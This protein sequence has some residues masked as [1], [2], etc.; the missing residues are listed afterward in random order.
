MYNTQKNFHLKPFDLALTAL[1][2]SLNFVISILLAPALKAII[3]Q[4]FLGA[5]L[6][7]PLDIFLAYIVWAVTR[8][9][10]FTLYFFIYGLLT[11]PTTIWGNMPGLFKP[12]LGLT[13]GLSLDLLTL[14][15]NPLSK[16]SRYLMGT[17]FPIIYWCWTALIWLAAGLPIVQLFQV[18]IHS[19]PVLNTIIPSGF[20]ATFAT[21]SLLTVPSSIIGVN[22]AVS[23]SKKVEKFIP[24]QSKILE[25]KT[26]SQRALKNV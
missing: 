13:I 24:H 21:L 10:I 26:K 19:T 15:F 20:I 23:V 18:M 6:M 25:P 11:A 12:F 4:V 1:M 14:K 7:V 22:F 2:S 17:L 8:K 3:P 5:F 9:N 16:I